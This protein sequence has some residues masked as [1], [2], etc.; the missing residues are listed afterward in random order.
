MNSDLR[1]VMTTC[2]DRETAD[3]IAAAL[4][5]RRLAACV[6]VLPGVTSTYRWDGKLETQSEVL[7]IIKTRE[8]E[9]DAMEAIIRAMSGYELPELIAV[10]ITAGAPAYLDWVA[11]SVGEI[12]E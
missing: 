4:V 8:Q 10:D 5:D 1:L 9:L 6:N 7:M 11:A 12:R 3:R 2:G